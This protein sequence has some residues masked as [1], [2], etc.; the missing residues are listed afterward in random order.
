MTTSPKAALRAQLLQARRTRSPE[1]RARDNKAWCAGARAL[2]TPTMRVAAYHPLGTEP[3]GPE[4]VDSIAAACC[5]VFLPISGTDGQLLWT[6]YDGPDAMRPGALGIA[7]PV[8]QRHSSAV[9]AQLDLILAPAMAVS[10]SGM[11][12]GKGAGYYDRAL[13]PLPSGRPPVVALVHS[14]EVCE[15]PTEDHDRPVDGVLTERGMSW[16]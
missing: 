9:L 15:V 4:L 12:L 13:A 2:L 7:E 8:G 3:G 10:P 11:R 14:T 16:L 1:Q 6:L 5:E